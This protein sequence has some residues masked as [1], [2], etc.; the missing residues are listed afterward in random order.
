M[1]GTR[2]NAQPS[3][4]TVSAHI[5]KLTQSSLFRDSPRLSKLL[6][7][8]VSRALAGRNADLKESVLGV[9]VF[10]REPGY[11]LQSYSVVRVEFAR[12][13]KKLER[14]YQTEG[15]E[16]PVR[17]AFLR[18]SYVPE[19]SWIDKM[20][21]GRFHPAISSHL[22]VLPFSHL[23]S[24]ADDEYFAAGLTEELITALGRIGG[25]RVVA[26][27]SSFALH[28][29]TCDVREIGRALKVSAVL[30]GSVRRQDNR[31][32]IHAQLIDA[33]DGTQLWAEKYERQVIDVFEI[34]DQITRAIV[35][36]LEL[37]L[38]RA[39]R[40]AA[41]S[42][43]RSVRAHELYL[44]GRYW[45]HRSN[46]S[47][48]ARAA[49]LF[50]EAIEC[51]PSYAA[52]Y[53]GLADACFNQ[54]MYAY[55]PPR[56]IIPQAEA[57]ARRALELDETSAEGH[58]SL[59]LIEGGLNWNTR[60]CGAEIS[61]CIQLNPSYALGLAK[62]GTSYLSPLGRFEEAHDYISQALEIDPLSPNFQADLALNYAFRGEMDRFEIEARKVLEMDPGVSK[63]HLY[64]IAALGVGGNWS[65]AVD[66]ADA[67]CAGCGADNPYILG[68]TAW[69][70]AG[71][72][73]S[74]QARAIQDRLITK[75]RSQYIPP[76][77]IAVTYL[78]SDSDAVFEKFEE[79][80]AVHE[81]LLRYALWQSFVFQPLY[82]DPRFQDLK[83][84]TGL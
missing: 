21:P 65:A 42:G 49:D 56:E 3:T 4:G 74:V 84:R 16:D 47:M 35:A 83:R 63:L 30:A 70:Y 11:D 28:G 44:K 18:G 8:T 5:D 76:G 73:Q 25:L 69:A 62:Y 1:T 12:L 50:R 36:A 67:A 17:V 48:Y 55:C 78:H 34:Q 9:E 27:T 75:A 7:H 81:P 14:Y 31:L 52:P 53:S 71:S 20:S 68:Y 82:S 38:P 39:A 41:S 72:G 79:A 6:Q 15:R 29:R 23:G 10:G 58:C 46:L 19:F 2:G 64:L 33:A 13:R 40:R 57:A 26:R 77:A 54:A 59:G 61:R 22:A 51:D 45:W 43:T 37:E 80:Y 24:N 60:A 32:R 66:A